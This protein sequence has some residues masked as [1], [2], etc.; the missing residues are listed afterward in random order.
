MTTGREPWELKKNQLVWRGSSTGG[1]RH[2]RTPHRAHGG[3]WEPGDMHHREHLALI[4]IDHPDLMNVTLFLDSKKRIHPPLLYELLNVSSV[5]MV[6]REASRAM[7]SHEEGYSLAHHR[8]GL[9]LPSK[10]QV[11]RGVAVSNGP[12]LTRH[13]PDAPEGVQVHD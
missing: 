9:F 6:D 1:K 8:P 12:S 4:A 5:T 7:P 3:R 13:L 2:Y 11:S 10:E